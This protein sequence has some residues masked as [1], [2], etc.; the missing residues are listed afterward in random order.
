[1]RIR[2][3]HLIS[4]WVLYP[5]CYYLIQYRKKVVRNNLQIAFPNKSIEERRQ[6]ERDFY[7]YFCDML[8]EA[9]LGRNFSE[10]QMLSYVSLADEDV[11]DVNCQKY[12]GCFI[13]MGHFMNWEWTSALAI[14]LAKKN[15]DVGV[16]Y[17]QLANATFDN[18]MQKLRS[19]KGGF[20][21]EMDKLL[22]VMIERRNNANALPTYY[23]MLADQR[24]RKQA[25]AKQHETQLLGRTI[26]MIT[27]T[28]Q[29]AMKFQY[30]IYYAHLLSS[31]RGYY[32]ARFIQIY[33]PAE[34]K[35]PAGE[36]TERFTR[37]L[38]K[39]ILEQPARWLWTHRRF[40]YKKTNLHQGKV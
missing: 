14:Q 35:L 2:I 29:L 26:G 18:I 38:E 1:M 34:G 37:H 5:I 10:E 16:I 31:K 33:D 39:N 20:L 28:E 40:L 15:K 32:S 36:I 24:P 6:I 25:L 11:M 30:P 7:L 19:K 3:G 23:A 21:I 17:K 8:I 13:M 27:G 9:W 12:G 4:R 22:R